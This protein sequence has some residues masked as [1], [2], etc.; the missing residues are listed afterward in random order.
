[1]TMNRAEWLHALCHTSTPTIDECIDVL[2]G[3]IEWLLDLKNTEQDGEWH[4]EGNVHIH[5]GMVLDELYR[6]L[7]DDAKHILGPK[8]Q[9]LI[10]AALLHD[11]GKTVRTTRFELDGIER[12]GSP[13]HAEHGRSYLAFKLTKL[14]L[15]FSVVFC[16]LN[17][18]GE[19]HAPK[20]L[21]LKNAPKSSFYSLARQADTELLY[22]LEIADIKGRICS[23]PDIQLQ[24]LEEFR[25]FAQEYAVWGRPL[26][27]R[28]ELA[29]SLESLSVSVQNYVYAHALHQLESGKIN[30]AAEAIGT[31]YEHRDKHSHLVLLC[32]PSGSGKTSWHTKHL[33]GYQLISLDDLREQFNGDRESQKNRGRIIQHAKELLRKSLRVNGK[34]IW[35]ATNLR[36]DF[37]SIVSGLG[38]DY[39]A[40]VTLVVFLSSEDDIYSNNRKRK[41]SVA[42]AVLEKQLSSFQ[43]P[44]LHE[45]HQSLFVDGKGVIQFCAGYF[46]LNS[47]EFE[48]TDGDSFS[49][50]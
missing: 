40:L 28:S 26:D 23:D 12:V 46:D 19:H 33:P 29:P 44:L 47:N 1:M 37:R 30:L 42:S 36:S 16:V 10:L 27:V 14:E 21:M 32:G 17:L 50:K 45:A 35:D 39:H 8:R 20:R 34:V 9:A 6:L 31:S 4:A 48:C 5:T 7:A 24:H 41:R 43:F 3:D 18:V 38:R 25:L 22:W 2:G 11:V 13:Q 15:S 49:L